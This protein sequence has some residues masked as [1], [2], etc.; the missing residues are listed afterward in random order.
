MYPEFIGSR[1]FDI[2][3]KGYFKNNAS[4]IFGM[5]PSKVFLKYKADRKINLSIKTSAF[6]CVCMKKIADLY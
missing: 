5:A 2:Q 1:L 6:L 4:L 3:G